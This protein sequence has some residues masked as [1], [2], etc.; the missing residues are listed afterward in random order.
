MDAPSRWPALLTELREWHR[1]PRLNALAGYI[2]AAVCI[3]IATLIR[4]GFGWLDGEMLPLVSYYPGIL[5]AALVGGAGPGVFAMLLSLLAV[6]LAFP[7][8]ILSFGPLAREASVSLSVY[9]FISLLSVWLAEGYRVVR[10]DAAGSRMLEW[11]TPI[12]V[13]LAAVLLTT[14]ALLAIDTH[15]GPDHLVIGYL[16]PTVIIAMHYGSTLAVVT[17]F[18]CGLA[19]AYFFFPPKLSFYVSDP[20]NLA[21]L[22]FFLLLAVIASKAVAVVTDDVRR[23]NAPPAARSS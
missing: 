5:L 13:A 15:L 3:A 19:A 23:R 21:E 20:I 8:P 9:V 18:A 1:A 22:G 16:L 7:A 12:L 2:L 6:W 10:G 11:A 4:F 14:F 17:S